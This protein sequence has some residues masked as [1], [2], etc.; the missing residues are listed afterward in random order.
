[1]PDWDGNG[2][3]DWHDDYVFNEIIKEKNKSS[4]PSSRPASSSGRLPWWFWVLAAL[5]L[6]FGKH[7]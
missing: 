1:M 2:K 7:S 6:L 3:N 5:L 4:H